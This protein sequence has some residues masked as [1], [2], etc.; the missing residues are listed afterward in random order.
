MTEDT[1]LIIF[2]IVTT[3]AVIIGTLLAEYLI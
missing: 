2:C 1:Q 3:L